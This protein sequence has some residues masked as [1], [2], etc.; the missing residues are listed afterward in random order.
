MLRAIWART[1]VTICSTLTASCRPP[2]RSL[3]K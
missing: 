1:G 3:S 2:S